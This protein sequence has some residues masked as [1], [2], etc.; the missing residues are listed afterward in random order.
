M[1]KDEHGDTPLH[2]A[3]RAG[4]LTAVQTLCHCGAPVNVANRSSL[5]PLHVAAKEGYIDI[6][7]VLCLAKANV[8]Q[9]N[10]DGLT[11]EI[12]ALAQ[13]HTETA[14]LLSRLKQV[15]HHFSYSLL[16]Q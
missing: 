9:K 16:Q 13:E 15:N 14:T 6:V 11:A 8:A 7:R 12:I 3:S 2:V 5:T 1:F 4:I 10:K